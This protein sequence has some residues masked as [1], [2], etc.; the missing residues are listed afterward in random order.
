MFKKIVFVFSVLTLICIL[1]FSWKINNIIAL[2]FNETTKINGIIYDGS[3]DNKFPENKSDA[4]AKCTFTPF[5][6]IASKDTYSLSYYNSIWDDTSNSTTMVLTNNGQFT[7]TL[8]AGKKYN[9]LTVESFSKITRIGGYN[10][11]CYIDNISQVQTNATT[12]LKIYCITIRFSTPVSN[13]Y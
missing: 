13:F 3:C 5:K 1:F 4:T 6:G 9:H 12:Q 2:Q 11:T 7:A 8:Q 10:I